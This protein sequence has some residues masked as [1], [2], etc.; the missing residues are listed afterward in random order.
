MTATQ[1]MTITLS[2]KRYRYQKRNVCGATWIEK[3]P[4]LFGQSSS[5]L[6]VMD[7]S[8]MLGGK[9]SSL[10][11]FFSSFFLEF[12]NV[13]S[14]QVTKVSR[15]QILARAAQFNA[16]VALTSCFYSNLPKILNPSIHIHLN[17]P[18]FV[19]FLFFPL[20]Y[21]LATPVLKIKHLQNFDAKVHVQLQVYFYIKTTPCMVLYIKKK[22]AINLRV[23]GILIC[24]SLRCESSLDTD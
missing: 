23:V 1:S 17:F 19:P 7:L 5:N 10:P 8:P 9:F 3:S 12:I 16:S 24:L 2:P 21:S 13:S 22:M 6:R 15:K 20:W 4:I 11:P 18:Y 14:L